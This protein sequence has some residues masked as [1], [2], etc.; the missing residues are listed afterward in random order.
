MTNPREIPL[1]SSVEDAPDSRPAWYSPYAHIRLWLITLVGLGLDLGSKQWAF[2]SLVSGRRIVLISNVFSL[3]TSLNKGALFGLGQNQAGLFIFASIV[4]FAL[5]IYVFARSSSRHGLFHVSL[6][7]I[8]GGAV[9][10]LFDRIFIGGQV[11][12]FLSI[13]VAVGRFKLWPWI[14]NGADVWLVI[15]F[16]LL[17][18]YSFFGPKEK[19]SQI[20]PERESSPPFISG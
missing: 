3:K 9:G 2:S 7:F 4:A 8:L 1:A 15:G 11:R 17:M 16:V 13:D 18:F 20:E 12:D 5:V 14:F 6:G 10:N 19:S